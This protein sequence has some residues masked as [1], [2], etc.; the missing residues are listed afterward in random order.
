MG[1][2]KIL[3][4][5]DFAVLSWKNTGIHSNLFSAMCELTNFQKK[6]PILRRHCSG[7]IH[8]FVYKIGS[9]REDEE[10]HAIFITLLI[11][12]MPKD[13]I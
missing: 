10:T 5:H 11:V 7:C 13:M 2:H 9:R 8:N 6:M 12:T 1:Q 3:A 4:V